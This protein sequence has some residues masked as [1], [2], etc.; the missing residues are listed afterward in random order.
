M[1]PEQSLTTGQ[2]PQTKVRVY[3]LSLWRS[4]AW[5]D[6]AEATGPSLLAILW[7]SGGSWM[8]LLALAILLPPPP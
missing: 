1:I 7:T 8:S 5:K 3:L 6:P 4:E 2:A